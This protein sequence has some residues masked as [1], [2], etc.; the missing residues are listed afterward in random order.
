LLNGHRLAYGG[1]TQSVDISAIP[2]AAVERLEVVTDGASAVYGSDAV[3]GVANIITRTDADLHGIETS[4][5][6]G[7]A[8]EGGLFQ[9]DAS[10]AAGETGKGGGIFAA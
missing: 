10:I 9:R 3:A 8:T 7:G 4:L 5:R 6:L 2:L 1:F